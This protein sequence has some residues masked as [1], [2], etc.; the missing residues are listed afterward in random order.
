MMRGVQEPNQVFRVGATG[1]GFQC[2]FEVTREI[3]LKWI[4]MMETELLP[5]LGADGPARIARVRHDVDTMLPAATD[6]ARRVMQ[7]WI[8]L[9]GVQERNVRKASGDSR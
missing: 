9:F 6:F 5:W 2:H 3:A 8:G 1:Y 4:M 7:G